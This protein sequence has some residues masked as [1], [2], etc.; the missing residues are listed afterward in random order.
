MF[1]DMLKN[2]LATM[3]LYL[4]NKKKKNYIL[5]NVFSLVINCIL[6]EE[7]KWFYLKEFMAIDKF[8][9]EK[10]RIVKKFLF[11]FHYFLFYIHANQTLNNTKK[12]I[13]YNDVLLLGT[14]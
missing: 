13:Y 7:Y 4:L 2:C 3:L 11:Q 9:V 6:M 14:T 10:Y 1:V 8:N 5:G 12:I